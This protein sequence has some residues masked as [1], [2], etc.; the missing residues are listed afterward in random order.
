[1]RKL[2]RAGPFVPFSITTDDGAVRPVQSPDRALIGRTRVVLLDSLR[3]IELI[4]R[5]KITSVS[6]KEE[7]WQP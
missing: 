5:R 4:N 1:M 7:A 3:N 2:L 6:I